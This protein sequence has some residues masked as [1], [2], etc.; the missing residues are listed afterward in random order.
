MKL[1]IEIDIDIDTT[2][3]AIDEQQLQSDL[4][5]FLCENEQTYF[6]NDVKIYTKCKE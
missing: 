4:E 6:L 2:S 5:E 3:D 1:K